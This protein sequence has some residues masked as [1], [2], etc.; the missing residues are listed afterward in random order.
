MLSLMEQGHLTRL[1]PR[2]LGW[3]VQ[4]MPSSERG[5]VYLASAP[6]TK[7]ARERFLPLASR[8][9]ATTCECPQE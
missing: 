5:A 6:F 3:P 2:L 4:W 1:V 7:Q 9:C 8:T